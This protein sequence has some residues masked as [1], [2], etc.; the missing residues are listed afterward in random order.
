M[1]NLLKVQNISKYFGGLAALEDVTFDVK[2][3][4][5]LGLIGP[6][7][8]GKTTLFNIICG[9]YKPSRGRVVFKD[10]NLVGLRAHE[11][12]AKGVGRIFQHVSLFRKETLMHNM[13]LAFHLKRK[14]GLVDWF[15]N[16]SKTQIE[17]DQIQKKAEETLSRMGLI[18]DRDEMVENL[19]Y[20]KQRIV[21]IAI[22]LS[23]EPEILLLDEPVTGMNPTEIAEM[24]ALLK[25]IR[26]QGVTLLMIEHNMLAIM[27]LANRIVVLDHG[28]KLVEGLPEEIKANE[29]VINAYL[30]GQKNGHSA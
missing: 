5:I 25:N 7:G 23:N 11:V 6:N 14:S 22:A 16:S 2:Q 8:A 30:G 28:R 27:N 19:P 24:V 3:G 18:E 1:E 9:V 15:L 21:A 26:S 4:E 10:S 20:G 29:D 12:A 17:E 13:L